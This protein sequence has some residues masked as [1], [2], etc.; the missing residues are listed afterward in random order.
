VI[1]DWVRAKD[2]QSHQD[3][4]EGKRAL[5]CL[6]KQIITLNWPPLVIELKRSNDTPGSSHRISS[7][8]SPSTLACW[9]LLGV[10]V[11]KN[12]LLG[13][14]SGLVKKLT[15][16]NYS[17]FRFSVPWEG[18]GRGCAS[19]KIF[20]RRD[21]QN[22]SETAL[23]GVKAGPLPAT[24]HPREVFIEANPFVLRLRHYLRQELLAHVRLQQLVPV[25]RECG[26]IP[27]FLV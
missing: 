27:H 20:H 14:P 6:G 9:G 3:P 19:A 11:F 13:Q 24:S 23:T 7:T 5:L 12:V 25:L 26:C 18:K 4:S 17:L 2:G 8:L 16:T 10:N 21:G 22:P 1:L 15:V